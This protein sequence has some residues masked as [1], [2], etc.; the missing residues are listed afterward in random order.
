[1]KKATT[2]REKLIE[3]VNRKAWWHVPPRDPEAYSKRGKFY[4]STFTMAE[5]YGRPNDHPER[6]RV[7]RPLV[8]DE[9]TISR[10]LGIP[11][12]HAGM[13]LEEIAKHD[14]RW[15]NAALAKRYDSIVLMAP[16]AF[17]RFRAGGSLPLSLELNAL[18]V[19]AQ[20]LPSSSETRDR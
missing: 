10:V 3:R 4:A 17:A 13:T 8:G 16:K 5:L 14:A 20:A 9:K 6:V 18:S 19:S 7:E 15:R 11:P 12:Q 1:M 2:F